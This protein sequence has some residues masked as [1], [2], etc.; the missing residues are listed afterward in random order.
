MSSI[1]NPA[2]LAFDLQL[3]P[4]MKVGVTIHFSSLCHCCCCIDFL[5]LLYLPEFSTD[6]LHTDNIIIINSWTKVMLTTNKTI[7]K[8]FNVS[9]NLRPSVQGEGCN[10]TKYGLGVTNPS[11][12]T[13]HEAL[14]VKKKRKDQ[15]ESKLVP[16]HSL[17]G[18]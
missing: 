10:V 4:Q 6:F 2:S 1:P 17:P 18:V 3:Y 5:R 9:I 7:R 16:M 13:R 11:K 12:S 15:N 8:Y 14:S